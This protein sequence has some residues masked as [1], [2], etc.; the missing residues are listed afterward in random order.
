MMI[1]LLLSWIYNLLV[2]NGTITCG[3]AYECASQVYDVTEQIR[4][5]GFHACDGATLTQDASA[6]LVCYGVR[7]CMD[8]SIILTGETTY[9]LCSGLFSCRN[10]S[11][12]HTG[13]NHFYCRADQSCLQASINFVSSDEKNMYCEGYR[14][15]AGATIH[16]ATNIYFYGSW[17]AQDGTIYST[18]D[19]SLFLFAGPYSGYGATV[20]C[21]QGG[22]CVIRC[23]GTSC[24][25][26]TAVC[27]GGGDTCTLSVTCYNGVHV[28]DLCPDGD[29]TDRSLAP[30]ITQIGSFTTDEN[31]EG[32]CDNGSTSVY[33]VLACDDYLECQYQTIQSTNG[34]ICCQGSHSCRYGDNITSEISSMALDIVKNVGIRCDAFYSCFSIDKMIQS[35]NNDINLYFTGTQTTT[36]TVALDTVIRGPGWVTRSNESETDIYCSGFRSCYIVTL[37]TGRRLFSIG[38]SGVESVTLINFQIVYCY[39]RE[40]CEQS[41]FRNVKELHCASQYSCYFLNVN[42]VDQVIGY[43]YFAAINSNFTNVNDYV[44]GI[45][46]LAFQNSNFSANRQSTDVSFECDGTYCCRYCIVDGFSSVTGGQ[47]GLYA[48]TFVSIS[49]ELNAIGYAAFRYSTL[50]NNGDGFDNTNFQV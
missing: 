7:S 8:A 44:Y 50:N 39:A 6:S 11:I 41:Q 46:Q 5:Y 15:C 22:E 28:C 1:V 29:N 23:E 25:N 36:S 30:N 24:I 4:C 14:A 12:I 19:Y 26:L 37:D 38:R 31:S 49:N 21:H 35:M 47:Y 18:D 34:P 32:I 20:Y 40:A 43:S 2:V 27:D 10:A 3:D 13:V 48:A 16:T 33:N 45:G 9:I 42:D 17:S